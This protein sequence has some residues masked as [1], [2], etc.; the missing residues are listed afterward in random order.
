MQILPSLHRCHYIRVKVQVHRYLDGSLAILHGPRALAQYD[1][2]G[3]LRLA[4]TSALTPPAQ[5]RRTAIGPVA[6]DEHA[7]ITEAR[8]PSVSPRPSVAPV[9]GLRVEQA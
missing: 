7:R 2:T 4:S 3:E 1:A 5:D 6:G 8:R 9:A